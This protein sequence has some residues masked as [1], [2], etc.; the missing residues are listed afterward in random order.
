MLRRVV[1]TAGSAQLAK[2][3]LGACDRDKVEWSSTAQCK[4]AISAGATGFGPMG[5][6]FWYGLSASRGSLGGVMRSPGGVLRLRA[7]NV[8]S[9]PPSGP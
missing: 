4:A 1:A 6:V 2:N 9:G 8:R 3:A 7:R 5:G